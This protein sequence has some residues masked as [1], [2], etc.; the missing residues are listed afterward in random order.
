MSHSSLPYTAIYTNLTTLNCTVDADE[1][2]SQSMAAFEAA[3]AERIQVFN[4]SESDEEVR[5]CVWVVRTLTN[6]FCF[7]ST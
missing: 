3:F 2:Q 1:E 6:P 4:D 5:V 7:V